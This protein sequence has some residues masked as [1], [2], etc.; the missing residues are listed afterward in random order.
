MSRRPS[1]PRSI[2][3]LPETIRMSRSSAAS[4]KASTE[5]AWTVAKTSAL[6]VP[7]RSSSSR[8]KAATPIGMGAVGEGLFG[9]EDMAF[10]P[11]HEL[12]AVRGDALDLRIM[13]MGV[14]E[15]GD[16]QAVER[17][18][19]GLG[20]RLG[21]LGMR[22]AG[23][24]EAVLDHEQAVLEMADRLGARDGR[25]VG[26]AQDLAAEGL[27]AGFLSMSS[28][29]S[30][31]IA[32]TSGSLPLMPGRPIGQVRRA[33]STPSAARRER[34]RARLV[35]RADQP[36][37]ARAAAE[38][39]R[40]EAIIEPVIV[41]EDHD[42]RVLG[43][44]GRAGDHRVLVGED[45]ARRLGRLGPAVIPGE[46]ERQAGR[47][48]GDGAADMA[49]AEQADG[50]AVASR[51]ARGSARRRSGSGPSRADRRAGASPVSGLRSTR[52]DRVTSNG[53][54]PLGHARPDARPAAGPARRSIGRAAARAD[55]P[56][57]ASFPARARGSPAP[58]P[59]PDVRARRRRSC[60]RGRS[61]SRPCARPG[62]AARSPRWR[63][64]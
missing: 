30:V 4:N 2:S 58:A 36:D 8:K 45:D 18:D 7:W 24:D 33:A 22:A 13:D 38:R 51:R 64:W 42:R 6:V 37:E 23:E 62:R 35:L 31:A 19:F 12:L 28:C 34:K 46:V 17:L 21:E 54:S 5:P 53:P 43:R 56:G 10:E 50:Q 27:H 44:R 15:A 26:N 52:S 63:G 32:I 29:A 59:S 60:P 16:D 1:G 55:N 25:I 40:G 11:L 9:R 39:G 61:R 20:E 49:R 47:A 57:R 3:T 48:R 41:G 14:D